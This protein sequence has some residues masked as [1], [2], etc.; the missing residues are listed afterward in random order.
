M[1]GFSPEAIV[2]LHDNGRLARDVEALA[3][4]HVLARHHIVFA[5]HV[6]A[7]LRKARAVAV[8]GASCKLALLGA[9]YPCDFILCR[10]M[11]MWTIQRSGFLF[12]PFIKKIA[13]FHNLARQNRGAHSDMNYCTFVRIRIPSA[14]L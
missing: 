7:E 6:G 5:H 8:V 10:L 9:H 3:T 4:A 2:L 12:L 11:A 1:R 14:A 13:L